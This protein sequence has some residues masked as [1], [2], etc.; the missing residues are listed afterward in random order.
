[1]TGFA[2]EATEAGG[3][4]LSW[5]IRTVN[6]RYLDV[7]LRLPEAFRFLE[8]DLRNR[9]G[10]A[11]K[12]GKVDCILQCRRQAGGVGEI[13]VNQALV[14]SVIRAADGIQGLMAQPAPYSALDVLRWPG[15]LGEAENEPE[16][17]R[18]PIEN[19]LDQA[20]AALVTARAREGRQLAEQ[21]QSR[22][23]LMRQQA[24]AAKIRLP[25][26][27]QGLRERLVARLAEFSVNADPGRLEQELV[28]L[29]QKLDVAEELDRLA[30]HLDEVERV[31]RA[32]EP[33]GRRLDFLMQELNREANT[34]GSKSA[35]TE[36]TRAS[37]EMK[38]LIEQMREQVQNIE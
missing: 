14:Q 9:V 12:R 34:L 27:L 16:S 37:V 35:D 31:L 5:E 30:E 17:L 29:A 4:A 8:G 1:M 20:L 3:F 11:V 2:L 6:H 28:F 21:I 23:V 7:S 15:V 25:Q 18:Q 13:K 38:V 32:K 10:G 26:V 19:L 36:T 24:E 33:I 22:C